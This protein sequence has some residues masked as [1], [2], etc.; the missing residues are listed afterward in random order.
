MFEIFRSFL[1]NRKMIFP[2]LYPS[3]SSKERKVDLGWVESWDDRSGVF[4]ITFGESAPVLLRPHS[5]EEEPFHLVE[6]ESRAPRT[7]LAHTGQQRFRVMQR[8]G[9]SCMVCG[10]SVSDL[11]ETAHIRPKGWQ[12]SDDPR[13]GLVLCATHHRA[14][15]A[16]L[17]ALEPG[18]LAVRFRSGGPTAEEMQINVESL[19]ALERRPHE[20]SVAWRWERWAG[21]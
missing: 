4:L 7:A 8:Y 15:D 14:Y 20:E 13:N 3:P 1:E 11:L 21:W 18:L 10:V 12:G 9:P 6:D 16:G 5:E 17:F 19:A 2:L